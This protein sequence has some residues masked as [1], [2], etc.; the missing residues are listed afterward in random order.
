MQNRGLGVAEAFGA[1]IAGAC[2]ALGAARF[3]LVEM[4]QGIELGVFADMVI[5][6]RPTPRAQTSRATYAAQTISDS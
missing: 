1:R 5:Q 4:A 2:V 3:E 6:H